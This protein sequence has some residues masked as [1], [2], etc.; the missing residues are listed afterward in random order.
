MWKTENTE[1]QRVHRI[2][3]KTGETRP[4]I[5]RFL[6]F[7]E[8]ELIFLRACELEDDTSAA[9]CDCFGCH[10]ELKN[11]LATTF[12]EQVTNLATGA[13]KKA[14]SSSTGSLSPS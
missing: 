13:V 3:M 10:G 5:I 12:Y 14:D 11:N 9:S 1:V 2:V 8:R 6:R 7:P 4:V